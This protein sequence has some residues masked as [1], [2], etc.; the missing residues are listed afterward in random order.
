MKLARTGVVVASMVVLALLPAGLASAQLTDTTWTSSTNGL[1]STV[2]NWSNTVPN[3]NS[4]RAVISTASGTTV[5]LDNTYTIGGLQIAS[6]YTLQRG[7]TDGTDRQLTI[8]AATAANT[9]FSNAGTISSGGTSGRLSISF[10]SGGSYANSGIMEATAGTTLN[11]M[12]NNATAVTL[13]NTGGTLRTVG[14]GTLQFSSSASPGSGGINAI[15]GGALSISAG[16]MLQSDGMSRSL[17]LTNVAF[18]NDGTVNWSQTSNN[19]GAAIQGVITL[20]GTTSLANSGTMT[21][22]RDSAFASSASAAGGL[23]V[24]AS[25]ASLTNN[26]G[27]S[28]RFLAKGSVSGNSNLSTPNANFTIT[29]NGTI[30]F[31]SQSTASGAYLSS[32]SGAS[33]SGIA[34]TL[35]GSGVLVMQVSAGGTAS[36]VGISGGNFINDTNHTIRGAGTFTQSSG[37]PV[38]TN[39]GTI[40]ADD[41]TSPITLNLPWVGNDNTQ[42]GAF[43][44]NG[45]FQATGAGGIVINVANFT[46]NGTFTTGAT[47]PLTMNRGF[48]V[49][50]NA[51]KTMTIGGAW[52]SGSGGGSLINNSGTI[53][54][55]SATTSSVQV[56]QTGSGAFIK[57]GSGDL[58]LTGANTSTGAT[59]VNAGTLFVNTGA[60]SALTVANVAGPTVTL[61]SGNTSGLVV[62]QFDGRGNITGILSGTT[63][64]RSG[65]ATTPGSTSITAAA[66]STL[67]SGN[68]TMNGG[69][70]N[71]G[72]GSHTVAQVIVAGGTISNGTLTT[73][74]TNYDVRS[75]AVSAALAG[76]S[77]TLTKT[78]AGTLTLSG[79]NTYTGATT[80]S[81]GMLQFGRVNSLYGGTTASWTATNIRTGSGATLAFNVGGTDEFTTGNVT[82][83]ITNLGASSSSTNG[84]NAGS[85]LGFD[86]TNASGGTFTIADAIANSTGASGGARGLRKLGTNTL[87]LT[88]SNS[89]TGATSVEAG[90]LAFDRVTALNSSSGIGINAGAILDYTGTADTLSRNITVAT[91]GTGTIRNSGGQKLTLSGTLTKDG[92][93][94]RLTGGTFDVTGQIVGASAN[95][96]LLVDGTSTVTLLSANPYNGPT[97]VN[98]ASTLV[99]GTNSAIPS[100]SIVTLGDGTTRGTLDLGSFTNSIGGLVFSGSGGT[101]RMAANQTA[102]PQLSTASSLTLGSNASLDLAGMATGAGAYKLISYTS[103]TGTFATVTGLS[104]DYLLRYDTVTANEI[105]AQRKAE[106]GTITATPV[107]NTI[108]TGGS[109]AFGYTV[110]NATPTGGSTLSFTSS[111]GS[112]VAGSSSGSAEANATSSS[113]SGLV[114]TGTSVGLGQTG[115]FTLTDPDAIG[116]PANGTVTVD[117][118]NHSLASFAAI[119]TV[120]KTLNFGT[121]DGTSWTGGDGGNGSLAYSIF[122]IASL[123]FSDAETAALDL[124]DWALTGGTGG[125]F[126]LGYSPFQNLASGSSNGF[127]A[128]VLS[129]GTLSDGLYTATYT[130]KFRDQQNLAGA[131]NTRNLTITLSANVIVVPEPGALALAGIGIAAAAYSLRSRSPSRKRAG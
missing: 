111:N 58:T 90:T 11:L 96:D 8:A 73:S 92:R 102:S 15:S 77:K 113:I 29:N 116:S 25:T 87:L 131:A 47:S 88:A 104:P 130:L 100:N 43:T 37:R 106:F 114:F 59:T 54:Y 101:V 12:G 103:R 83:L 26:V 10:N 84:M 63:Y 16:G 81:A 67:S 66:Y 44:N 119:D 99:L 28:M 45:T 46:N 3:A 57:S 20:S 117:V 75:G 53:T 93:V 13:S 126:S 70:L 105:T 97:F 69:T 121:F 21:Y 50:N 40:T 39:N 34:T 72:T 23:T 41:A 18:T 2:G 24:S 79:S 56:G 36:N 91:S 86:T 61:T 19:S 115:S 118:L 124:Y 7:A 110:A 82:T 35:S 120:S 31:E 71:L 52:I 17:T 1:W 55:D 5:T 27:A 109:T 33:T 48:V 60:A 85:F 95:S 14:T 123:G 51:G 4:E 64:I 94:L 38:F 30:T 42:I 129:P 122:N 68:L 76:V 107:A 62:G 74:T 65:G 108:I 112:N 80:V 78:T 128:S 98:Q 6:G 9:F 127:S 125:I 89:F 49:T 22:T 32:A